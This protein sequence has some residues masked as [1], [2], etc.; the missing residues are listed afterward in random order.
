MWTYLF[1]FLAALAADSGPARLWLLFGLG[2]PAVL[3]PTRLL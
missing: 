1:D 3:A 2:L